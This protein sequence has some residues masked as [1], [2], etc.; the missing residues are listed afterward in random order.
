MFKDSSYAA[1]RLSQAKHF[2]F[3]E[4]VTAYLTQALI[5][6]CCC[7]GVVHSHVRNDIWGRFQDGN[8]IRTSDI[9]SVTREGGFWVL[10]TESQSRYVLV[11]FHRHG[12]RQSLKT[13]M[14][15]LSRGFHTT[16]RYLQ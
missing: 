1:R 11:T 9:H 16:P 14:Q 8:R 2:P 5:T 12:G 3:I 7:I 4:P 6:S 15:F 13:F 10:R